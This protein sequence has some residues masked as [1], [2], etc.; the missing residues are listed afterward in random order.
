MKTTTIVLLV[1][2]S[3]SLVFSLTSLIIVE[4]QNGFRFSGSTPVRNVPTTTPIP[5][6]R[7]SISYNE[8]SKEEIGSSTFVT[9][10]LNATYIN[11]S[12]IT[13]SDSQFYLGLYVYR[14]TFRMPQNTVSPINNGTF[15][16][17]LSHTTQIFELS[18]EFPTISFNGMDN[19][20]TR[21]DLGYSGPAYVYWVNQG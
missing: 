14:M 21:Y 11:G 12:D 20:G 19:T 15:T 1:L 18:F 8:S 17:G 10:T 3:L 13:L 7:L 2:V 9:L 6:N 5:S 4:S 16:L